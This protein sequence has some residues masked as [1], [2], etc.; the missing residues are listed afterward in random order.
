MSIPVKVYH[1]FMLLEFKHL[2]FLMIRLLAQDCE[3]LRLW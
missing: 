3:Q 2:F 1:L